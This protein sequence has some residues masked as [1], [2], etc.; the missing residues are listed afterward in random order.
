MT[1]AII[2][3]DEDFAIERLKM[4]LEETG[5]SI[6]VIAELKNTKQAISWLK[7]NQA[8]L[9]FLDINLSDGIA[10]NIFEQVDVRTPIIFTTA[11][12][13][14]A[15]RAFEQ[16][17]IDYLLKPINREKL[18]KSIEKFKALYTSNAQTE[19]SSELQQLVELMRAEKNPKRFIVNV[20]NR[21]KIVEATDVAC[22]SYDNKISFIHTFDGKR[23]PIDSS[24][25]QLQLTLSPS[26]FFR[27]NR[28]YLVSRKAITELYYFSPTKIKV[29]MTPKPPADVL[30]ARDK[31]GEFKRWLTE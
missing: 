10:F 17:S 19:P 28:Q 11:Y 4:L 27:V 23:Y 6:K 2:I 22:F 13:E 29:L 24:L 5:D 25:K 9:I 20:G 15:L 7:D 30:V 18:K 12:H 8:D 31:I 16:F 21:V 14:Y 26:D 3:E 1:Q